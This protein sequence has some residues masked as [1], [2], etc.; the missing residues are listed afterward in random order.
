MLFRPLFVLAVLTPMLPSACKRSDQ[1]K[2][3][4][5]QRETVALEFGDAGTVQLKVGTRPALNV[6]R[7]DLPMLPNAALAQDSGRVAY[8]C[9]NGS[10]RI[11]YVAGENLIV[12]SKTEGALDWKTLP[13]FSTA[14]RKLYEQGQREVI[15]NAVK[16]AESAEGLGDFMA[17]VADVD[18]AGEWQRAFDALVPAAKAKVI[19]KLAPEV[20][21][22]SAPTAAF[23]RAVRVVDLHSQSTSVLTR[24]ESLLKNETQARKHDAAIA[25]LVRA[26]ITDHPKEMGELACRSLSKE[27]STSRAASS[28]TLA[29]L[30]SGTSCPATRVLLETAPCAP[31]L[32]CTNAGPLSPR[33]TTTQTEALCTKSQIDAFATKELTRSASD[34]LDRGEPSAAVF[35][36]GL[37]AELP[38]SFTRAHAR[39]AY[40]IASASEGKPAC[41]VDL[42]EGTPC[43]CSEAMLR[44]AACHSGDALTYR[45]GACAFTINDAKKAITSVISTKIPR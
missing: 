17:S 44:D 7:E 42:K 32:R 5:P 27:L 35:A 23:E 22:S 1:D 21:G 18:D 9:A 29:I 33:D 15:L 36:L 12:G 25:V 3:E 28:L 20:T 45:A 8:A 24:L 10:T 38:E 16:S 6:P 4:T 41:E 26:A 39:R 30:K 37:V 19:S 40:A 34:V 13:N 31:E 43:K 2:S 11:V 14:R